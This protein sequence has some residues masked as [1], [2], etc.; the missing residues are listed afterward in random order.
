MEQG[1]GTVTVMAMFVGCSIPR[2]RLLALAGGG[3]REGR[4]RLSEVTLAT[5]LPL[6]PLSGEEDICRRGDN[7]SAGWEGRGGGGLEVSAE[8]DLLRWAGSLYVLLLL[9]SQVPPTEH[10]NPTPCFIYSTIIMQNNL[11]ATLYIVTDIYH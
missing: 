3:G 6:P 9:R 7:G 10:S 4:E 1:H 8:G 11:T 2:G 5:P